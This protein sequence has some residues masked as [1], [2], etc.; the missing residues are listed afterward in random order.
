MQPTC[1]C[2]TPN[3]C[4]ILDLV[5][6]TSQCST[7]K[8]SARS[9]AR[10]D[11][12]IITS[13][14]KTFLVFKSERPEHWR[15]GVCRLWLLEDTID[16]DIQ[17][18]NWEA[19]TWSCRRR[20]WSRR[21]LRNYLYQDHWRTGVREK[22]K[23]TSVRFPAG[24]LAAATV[25][26]ETWMDEQHCSEEK[27]TSAALFLRSQNIWEEQTKPN[28]RF[29]TVPASQLEEGNSAQEP[30]LLKSITDHCRISENFH[31]AELF[32]FW[33]NLSLSVMLCNR[34]RNYEDERPSCEQDCDHLEE[35]STRPTLHQQ[36]CL[37]LAYNCISSHRLS[38]IT[39]RSLR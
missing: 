25:W 27:T 4:T 8:I 32:R 28:S 34:T 17:L 29:T 21:I 15:N 12:V 6:P 26:W 14:H 30:L 11:G 35:R 19:R 36:Y 24:L 37:C 10:A 39:H 23:C 9:G 33:F 22:S 13:I 38:I 3:D 7:P 20:W 1:H 31:T 18:R 5:D 2:G 16:G